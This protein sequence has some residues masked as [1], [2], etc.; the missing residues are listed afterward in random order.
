V[1]EVASEADLATAAGSVWVTRAVAFTRWV[2][3]G[4]R[5]TQ[6]G[7]L[8]L[9][10]ARELVDHLDTQ[11][12]LDPR[13]GDRVYRTKS[14]EELPELNTVVEWAKAARLVRVTGG[15]L[16]AVKKNATLLERPLPLW[17]RM[18]S[19][20]GALGPAIC[21]PG[22]GESLLRRHFAEGMQA[23]LA[24]IYVRG[25]PV[26]LESRGCVRVG[27]GS[28]HPWLPD[29]RHHRRP[30]GHVATLQRPGRPQRRGCAGAVRRGRHR[31]CVETVAQG[32]RQPVPRVRAAPR[33]SADR[34][35]R[36]ASLAAGPVLP[37]GQRRARQC[38]GHHGAEQ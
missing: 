4:R 7:R 17:E 20:F 18:F 13:V 1:T 28:R 25:G 31:R 29:R 8:T 36:R 5:L 3:S 21:P 9:A 33:P 19:T 16:V 22:W 38:G 12:E 32:Q 15:K 37:P 2:G 10:H 23:V 11:D 6:T 26:S 24:G 35:C 14:S 34:S 30:A 27:L